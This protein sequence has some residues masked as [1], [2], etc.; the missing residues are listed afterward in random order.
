MWFCHFHIARCSA[1]HRMNSVSYSDPSRL[2]PTDKHCKK[3]AMKV[4]QIG[5]IW[6]GKRPRLTDSRLFAENLSMDKTTV[7]P[8]EMR[9]KNVTSWSNFN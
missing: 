5:V 4:V 1:L 2:R 8:S 7:G 9:R 6:K 3:L